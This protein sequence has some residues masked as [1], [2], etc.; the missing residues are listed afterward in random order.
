MRL[1][2]VAIGLLAA[3]IMGALGLWQMQVYT[4]QG[5]QAA[6]NAA[7]LVAAP[8][9][10]AVQGEQIGGLW[11]R[12]VVVQGHYLPDQQVRVVGADGAVRVLTAFLLPDGRVVPIVRGLDTGQVPAPP[13]GDVRQ[14]GVLLPPEPAGDTK[15]SGGE[16][17]SVRLQTLAQQW[18]QH[19]VAGFVTLSAADATA[20]GMTPTQVVLPTGEGSFRNS[21]YAVQWWVFGAFALVMSVVIARNYDRRGFALSDPTPASTRVD[22]GATSP[23]NQ[24]DA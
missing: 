13:T 21:G 14:T 10:G 6:A 20:Q 15:V 3:W 11:G 1:L 2:I 17:A 8:L 24:E 7:N 9:D 4:Q 5:Q 22:D 23:H 19:L 12:R 18:P 16:L